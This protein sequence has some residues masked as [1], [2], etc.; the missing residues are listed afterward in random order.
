MSTESRGTATQHSPKRL[1]LLVAENGLEAFLPLA[2]I[3]SASRELHVSGASLYLRRFRFGVRREP[4]AFAAV[5]VIQVG[6]M[7]IECYFMVG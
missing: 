5:A 1:Q 7:D 3:G 2:K 4:Q 6:I